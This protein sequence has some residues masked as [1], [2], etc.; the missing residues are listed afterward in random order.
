MIHEYEIVVFNG[1]RYLVTAV[2]NSTEAVAIPMEV[3]PDFHDKDWGA[4]PIFSDEFKAYY[5]R[6]LRAPKFMHLRNA[7]KKAQREYSLAHLRAR[8]LA[9][10]ENA[11]ILG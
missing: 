5:S 10:S 2:L 6:E 11:L 3:F 9:V 7:W 1:R 8:G 4:D